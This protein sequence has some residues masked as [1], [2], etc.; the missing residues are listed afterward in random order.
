[1]IPG[2]CFVDLLNSGVWTDR[3]KSA[4]LLSVLTAQRDPRLLMCL[5]E[6]ALKSLIEMAR[7]SYL[8]HANSAQLMLGRIAGIDEKTLIAMLGKQEVEAIINALTTQKNN[9][10]N[11][12][13]C[14]L[15]AALK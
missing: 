4:E 3:N 6:Q 9:G 13:R 2:E 15:C 14:P 10:D 5:R 8:G 12:S 11:A 1:M 7:W